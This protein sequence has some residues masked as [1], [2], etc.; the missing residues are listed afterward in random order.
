MPGL[1]LPPQP[2]SNHWPLA[3]TKLYC[4]LTE[5]HR[6]EQL[7]QGCYAALPRV[8]FEPATYWSHVQHCT[9]CATVPPSWEERLQNDLF[10]CRGTLPSLSLKLSH[11]QGICTMSEYTLL[12]YQ[13][14]CLA[15]S[16]SSFQ[17]HHWLHKLHL[18]C[19]AIDSIWSHFSGSKL[20][21]SH[22]F[23]T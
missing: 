10:L 18:F 2:Q 4:L 23:F 20:S 13:C 15:S 8:G 11:K 22:M 5:A 9:R 16:A 12:H 21:K 1:R 14:Q 7:A 17:L 19:S 3:G 6:C